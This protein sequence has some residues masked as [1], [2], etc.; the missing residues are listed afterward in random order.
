MRGFSVEWW[1]AVG[2][3][4][5]QALA[6]TGQEQAD[7]LEALRAT[8]AGL[9]DELTRLLDEHSALQSEHFLEDASPSLSLAPPSQAGQVAGAYTLRRLIGHGGMGSVWLAERSDGRFDGVAAVKLLGVS[10]LGP[11]GKARFRRE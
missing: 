8:D 4:L 3:F 7:W 10:R 6:L 5:E 2:P 9:A 11:E 1:R